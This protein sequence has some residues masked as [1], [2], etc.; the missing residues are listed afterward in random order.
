MGSEWKRRGDSANM[1]AIGGVWLLCNFSQVRSN[2]AEENPR[3]CLPYADSDL[4]FRMCGY[5]VQV[6]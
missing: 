3:L 1:I 4:I 2:A 6:V 5:G